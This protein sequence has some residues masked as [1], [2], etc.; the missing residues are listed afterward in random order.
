MKEGEGGKFVLAALVTDNTKCLSNLLIHSSFSFYWYGRINSFPRREKVLSDSNVKLNV[1]S[2]VFLKT[3]KSPQETHRLRSSSIGPL[4]HP[5]IFLL[6]LWHWEVTPYS[7][8]NKLKSFKSILR[9]SIRGQD[10]AVGGSM[11]P[12]HPK[13]CIFQTQ[14]KGDGGRNG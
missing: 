5:K 13:I 7:F 8:S 14:M 3:P 6:F 11:C 12:L 4:G 10:C 2:H 9:G 1:R